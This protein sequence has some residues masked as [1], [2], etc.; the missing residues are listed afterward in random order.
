M[1]KFTDNFSVTNLFGNLCDR[2]DFLLPELFEKD[3]WKL[4][5]KMYRSKQTTTQNNSICTI[6]DVSS[7]SSS[8]LINGKDVI[9]ADIN[10]DSI[11]G[12]LNLMYSLRQSYSIE[13]I[14]WKC[15]NSKNGDN[16]MSSNIPFIKCSNIS[17]IKCATIY[18]GS[19]AVNILIQVE[20]DEILEEVFP[21]LLKEPSN[22]KLI[23][24]PFDSKGYFDIITQTIKLST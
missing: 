18:S 8:Y 20:K 12:K 19:E 24:V 3:S 5:G 17:L 10:L 13:G 11:I 15:K 6:Q 21:D 22:V 16:E 1:F 7:G 4:T 2:I 14:V 23:Q 9:E